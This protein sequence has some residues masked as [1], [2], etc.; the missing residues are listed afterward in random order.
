MNNI[1]KSNI[2]NIDTLNF[3][4]NV[5]DNLDYVELYGASLFQSIIITII[6]FFIYGYCIIIQ[7]RQALADDWVNQRCKPQNIP[8]AGFISKPE[9]KTAFEYTNENFQYCLQ[10]ILLETVGTT[11]QPF[12]YMASMVTNLFVKISE[13]LNKIRDVL[14][15]LVNNF[16]KIAE[17]VFNRIMNIVIPV[18]TILIA[19]MDS[20]SKI[21]AIITTSFY[22][23]LGAYYS[24]QALM[25]AILELI[26]KMLVVLV[27]IIIGLWILPFTWPIAA[28]TSIIFLGIAI[29]LAIIIYFMTEVLH[30]ET[31]GIP[32]LRC[33]DKYTNFT[34]QDKSIK[35][36]EFLEV[37][38]ILENNVRITAKIKV[39]SKDLDM[40]D[41]DGIIVSG[42]HKINYKNIWM[43]IREHPNS[44]LLQKYDEPYLYCLNTSSKTIIIKNNIFSDWDEIYNEKLNKVLTHI[45]IN[46][47]N[48]FTKNDKKTANQ[49]TNVLE[50]IH[51]YLDDGFDENVNIDTFL[52]TNISIKDI[53]IGDK[54]NDTNIVYGVVEIEYNNINNRKNL[55]NN[56]KNKLYHLLTTNGTF[57][58][59]NKIVNDYNYYIDKL[60]I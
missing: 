40:Y 25:G 24:L 55:G 13:A 48:Q 16:T 45:D 33:F 31:A 4:S 51:S 47:N 57:Y 1:N 49:T 54:L 53:K 29:P 6:V 32:A 12:Q 15:N 59:N 34:L 56:E 26:I 42:N 37:G 50:N 39:T 27:I 9:G 22:T 11:F 52:N 23:M 18:Q 41:L 2:D 5:Y 60:T 17:D 14:N 38:D 7:N 19:L 8:F 36:I 3:I 44:K 21:Q 30:I 10:N 43:S 35:T 58:I 28:T 46:I 20:F